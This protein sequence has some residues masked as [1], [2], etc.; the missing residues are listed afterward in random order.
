MAEVTLE[1]QNER[2]KLLLL[3]ANVDT[4]YLVVTEYIT[5]KRTQALK[6]LNETESE[7]LAFK[8]N[9]F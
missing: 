5:I 7:F 1:A 4:P 2:N 6:Y 8:T 3:T 9:L